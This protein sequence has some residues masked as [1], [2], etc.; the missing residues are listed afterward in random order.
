MWVESEEEDLFRAG[1]LAELLVLP[2]VEEEFVGEVGVIRLEESV[3]RGKGTRSV[4][5]LRECYLDGLLGW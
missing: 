5:E 1:G 3:E 2:V 4:S